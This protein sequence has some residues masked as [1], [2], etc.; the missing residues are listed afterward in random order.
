MLFLGENGKYFHG[1]TG[2]FREQAHRVPMTLWMSDSLIQRNIYRTK[3]ENSKVH[4]KEKLSHDNVFH[5]LLDC[6]N[7]KSE[8]LHEK[9]SVC[10]R[11]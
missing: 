7:V 4:I 6:A 10:A 9:L 2:D 5:S 8:M 3:L 1:N 11:W